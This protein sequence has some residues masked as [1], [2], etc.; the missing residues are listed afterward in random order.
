[1][2]GSDKEEERHLLLQLTPTAAHELSDD[3]NADLQ[4]Y[5]QTIQACVGYEI[6]YIMDE[7]PEMEFPDYIP[8]VT[9]APAS[10]PTVNSAPVSA[11]GTG[12]ET[13]P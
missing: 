7:D 8:H 11:S 10:S 12:Q 1:M 5:G 6:T 13:E 2:R 3:I 9:M 4:T